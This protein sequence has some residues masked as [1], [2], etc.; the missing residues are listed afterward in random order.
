MSY[1]VKRRQGNALRFLMLEMTIYQTM[2]AGRH[3][4]QTSAG[5][6]VSY[7]TGQ[8]ALRSGAAM[9]IGGVLV[10]I[11]PPEPGVQ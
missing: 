3:S 6:L 2:Q 10:G 7:T 11:F 4:F 9:L 1:L 8:T 5:E